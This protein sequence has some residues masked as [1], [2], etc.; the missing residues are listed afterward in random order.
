MDGCE[1]GLNH[2]PLTAF[3]I[4]DMPVVYSAKLNYMFNKH[5][6]IVEKEDS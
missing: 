2:V 3:T 6:Q 5:I 4:I 1:W